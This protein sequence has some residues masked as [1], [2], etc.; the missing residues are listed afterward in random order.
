MAFS[1]DYQLPPPITAPLLLPHINR[2]ITQRG[3]NGEATV[4][5]PHDHLQG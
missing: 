3:E 4:A 5:A 2:D 1:R